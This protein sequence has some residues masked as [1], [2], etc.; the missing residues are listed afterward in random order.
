MA[1]L[2]FGEFLGGP[3]SVRLHA[4][5]SICF[6]GIDEDHEVTG[7]FPSRFQQHGGVEH[8]QLDLLL[9]AEVVDRLFGQLADFWMHDRFEV[10][11][12]LYGICIFTE[13]KP[14]E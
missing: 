11:S 2:A 3:T 6:G 5:N 12:S 7:I 13:H 1:G 14:S 8:D 4:S 9:L 10:V